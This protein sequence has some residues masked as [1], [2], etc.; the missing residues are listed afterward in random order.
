MKN[1]NIVCIKGNFPTLKEKK[2]SIFYLKGKNRHTS[3]E[4]DTIEH[5]KINQSMYFCNS[6]LSNIFNNRNDRA[7]RLIKSKPISYYLGPKERLKRSSSDF[8]ITNISNKVNNISGNN[9]LFLNSFNTQIIKNNN[10]RHRLN[11][12]PKY[13]NK[14]K[15]KED[16]DESPK[17]RYLGSLLK[18]KK[19]PKYIKKKKKIIIPQEQR[20]DYY[21]FIDR[22]RK[23]FFNPKAT[24]QYVHEKNS[25]YLILS[26]EKSKSYKLLQS[27]YRIDRSSQ[28]EEMLERR[29]KVPNLAFK[30]Q[31]LLKQIRILF[32]E[33]FKFNYTLFSEKF[34]DKY[35]NRVNF[36]YDIYR[37]PIFK[38]NLVKIKLHKKEKFG[39]FGYVDWKYIN[40]INST[41][42]NYLNRLKTK[43]QREKDEHELQLKELEL[44][45]REEE[46]DLTRN[47]NNYKKDKKNKRNQEIVEKGELK[48]SEEE[49]D[50][51]KKIIK[52]EENYKNI[53]QNIEKEEQLK[54]E[55]YE[56][57]YIIEEYFL[58]KKNCDNF[59]VQIASDRLRYIYFNNHD[60]IKNNN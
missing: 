16:N 27:D 31:N 53:M 48:I 52:E 37:V 47:N 5:S 26:I 6:L 11:Y 29:D 50:N 18:N 15:E 24:S 60:Y 38:N 57:L 54:Q 41:T 40:V 13:N 19:K 2:K 33:D 36:I 35:E 45:K 39:N 21:D 59:R 43:I 17:V 1:V 32:S 55:K 3:Q 49:K 20:K 34:Y 23:L 51:N 22:R 8:Y 46:L 10:S 44:K 14:Q 9:F 28:R 56:D 42:W 25:E 7:I 30:T 58:H 12:F 4:S